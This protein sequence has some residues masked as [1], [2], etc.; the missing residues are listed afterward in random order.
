MNAGELFEAG[1]HSGNECRNKFEFE[2]AK[3]KAL[4][5]F[6]RT[7]IEA[8]RRGRIFKHWLWVITLA[9]YIISLAGIVYFFA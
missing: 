2:Q 8:E 6:S 1:A 9:M 3:Q 4:K 5:E 7:R